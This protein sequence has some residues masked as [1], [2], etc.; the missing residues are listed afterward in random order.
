M[1]EGCEEEY[2]NE[3]YPNEEY[4]DYGEKDDVDQEFAQDTE[5]GISDEDF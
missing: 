1:N 3:E 4:E 5:E 2:P